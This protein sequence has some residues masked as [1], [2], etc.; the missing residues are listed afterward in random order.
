MSNSQT[1]SDLLYKEMS[2]SAN[3]LRKENAENLKK[4]CDQMVKDKVAITL[5]GVAKRCLETFGSPA[6]TT[7]TNT[8]SKLGDYVRARKSE[9][10]IS[11][12]STIEPKGIS[13]KVSDPV[14]AQEVKILEETIKGLRK[15]NNALRACYKQLDVDIDTGIRKLLNNKSSP[16]EPNNLALESPKPPSNLI[17]AVTSI[18]NHLAERG[19]GVYRG[20]YGFNKKTILTA[21]EIESLRDLLG[22]DESEFNA[23]YSGK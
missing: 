13:N 23:R 20:R 11:K 18:L 19:Y 8:G 12:L 4:I 2:E 5:N 1:T 9:Q 10:N 22:I 3:S 16:T 21:A 7:V 15:E 14:V 17:S 6:I